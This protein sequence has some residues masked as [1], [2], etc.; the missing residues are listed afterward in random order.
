[1]SNVENNRMMIRV[2]SQEEVQQVTDALSEKQISWHAEPAEDCTLIYIE[3]SDEACA[4][5][6]LE[7]IG[8]IAKESQEPKEQVQTGRGKSIA[9]TLLMVILVALA[10]FGTDAIVA[11]IQKMFS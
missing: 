3:E 8:M 5:E 9:L 11:A 10:V 1:M 2:E 4:E 6:V 7:Q